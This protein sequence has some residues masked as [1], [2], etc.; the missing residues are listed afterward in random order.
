MPNVTYA[1]CHIQAICAECR[2]D[3]CRC[4]QRCC[5]EC[6]STIFSPRPELALKY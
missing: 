2:Y 3:E 4:D 1:H 6:R 5:A